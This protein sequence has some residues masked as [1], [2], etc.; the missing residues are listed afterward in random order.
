MENSANTKASKINANIQLSNPALVIS[1]ED[2]WH[3]KVDLQADLLVEDNNG[4]AKWQKNINIITYVPI[5]NFEDPFYTVEGSVSNKINKTSY[6]NP[7][8]NPM[9]SSIGDVSNLI[10]HIENGLYI[11]SSNA[12]NFIQRM[13]GDFSADPGGNGIESLVYIPKLPDSNK[14][15]KSSVDW[16]YFDSTN[17]PPAYDISGISSPS[18]PFKLDGAT[19]LSGTYGV[20]CLSIPPLGAC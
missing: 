5:E 6:G 13:E 17:N 11:A 14:F 20:E 12:P 2:P 10:K 18:F 4:L 7:F 8:V 15:D 9:G 3:V 16:I 19:I 1:Q